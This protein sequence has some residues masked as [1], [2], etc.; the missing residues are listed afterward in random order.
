MGKKTKLPREFWAVNAS[1]L[2]ERG[3]YYGMLAVFSYHLIYNVGIESWMVGILTGISMG[4]INFLP[5]ISTA[6]ASKYGF[7]KLLLFS[8]TTLAVGYIVLGFGYSIALIFL[9]VIIMGTGSG[10]E[11]ALIAASISHS[12]DEKNRNYAFN[13]YYWVINI[14]AFFIP[15]SL[16]FLFI[17]AEYGSVFFLMALFIIC[18]FLIIILSYK[19]PIKPDPSIPALKAVKGLKVIFKDPKFVYILIIFSGCWFMLYMRKPFMPIFMIDFR[20]L[21]AWFIPVLAALNPGTIITL[22]Q[23]WAYIIKDRKIDPLKMLIAGVLIVAL[24]FLI[25]GFSLN[26]V[27]FIAGIII[28]SFGEMVS[29]PAFLSYVSKIPPKDK[30][31]IYMGYSFIPLAIAG[32][33]APIVGGFLYFYIAENMAMGRLF[34]AIV[35]S[36]GLVS[37]SAF[38]HYDRRYNKKKKIISKVSANI[39]VLFIPVILIIGFSLGPDPIYRG[40]LAQE[41]IQDDIIDEVTW[42]YLN[43]TYTFVDLLDEAESISYDLSSDV[44]FIDQIVLRLSWSDEN[45][46]RRLRRFKNTGD[47]FSAKIIIDDKVVESDRFTNI[48]GESGIINLRYDGDS[49]TDEIGCN[50]YVEIELEKCGDYYPVF[51]VNMISIEDSS[52][53]FNLEIVVTYV[54]SN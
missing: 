44:S 25:A 43:E 10:F 28:L 36:I 9:A 12:S 2:F 34:W 19:N 31:S 24:G 37:A 5:L 18:S 46:I 35:A 50:A 40:A 45:D 20:I 51:G 15:L 13:I 3:A 53:M 14:G 8:Y 47:T 29:Y 6:L 27:I 38:L 22:G 48:H 30:R 7:K 11:K 42:K 16:T 1:N 49:F 4:L 39:P 21:P 17:P 41:D 32:V 33:T 54:A 52:N 23:V 26:P